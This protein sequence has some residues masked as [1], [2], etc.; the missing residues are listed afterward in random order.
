[1]TPSQSLASIRLERTFTHRLHTLN[2]LSDKVTQSGYESEAGIPA[3]EAR[4]L[5]A[6]G[7]YGALSVNDLAREAN[8]DKGQASRAAQALVD[9][10]LVLKASSATDGRGVVLTLTVQGQR[11]WERTMR[12]IARRNLE[13]TACLNDAERE[14]LDALLD[15]LVQ[16]A[17]HCV[18]AS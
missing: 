11:V 14:Q 17:R 15:K 8:L 18:K 4:C 10:G 2:K 12:F 13:I 5:A 6:V 16:H 9:K 7:N 1:M 3:H